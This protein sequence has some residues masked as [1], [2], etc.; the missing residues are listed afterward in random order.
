[1]K[2]L[3]LLP[4]NLQF[5]AEEQGEGQEQQQQE[6]Q[7]E[8]KEQPLTMEAVQKLIQSE[9]DKIRTQYSQKVKEKE[10]EL[11]DVKTQNMSELEKQQ[12][13]LDK[14]RNELERQKAELKQ[15]KLTNKVTDLLNEKKLP[16]DFKS[17]LIGN[18]EESTTKNV[19]TFQQTWNTAIQSAVEERFKQNGY[20]PTE[21]NT[22]TQGTI[23]KEQFQALGYSERIKIFNENPELYK[24]LNS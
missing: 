16:L 10:K 12:Y 11:E 14:A 24:Q 15:E 7:T 21:G 5:F 13:E 23:T 8:T 9:T 1:M 22:T 19:E 3:N 20:K 2:K 18:D 6:Q 17:W 4:L